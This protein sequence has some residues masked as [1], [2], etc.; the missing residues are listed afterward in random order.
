[1]GEAHLDIAA[2]LETY[3]AAIAEITLYPGCGQHCTG[4]WI[5]QVDALLNVIIVPI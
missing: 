1:M 3:I 2:E 5:K 4:G